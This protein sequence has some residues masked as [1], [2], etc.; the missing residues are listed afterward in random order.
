MKQVQ[1]VCKLTATLSDH[2]PWFTTGVKDKPNEVLLVSI[3]DRLLRTDF[4]QHLEA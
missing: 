3:L 4:T 2:T 1:V